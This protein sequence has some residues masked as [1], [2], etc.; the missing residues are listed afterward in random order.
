MNL[1]GPL[2]FRGNLAGRPAVGDRGRPD[3]DIKIIAR[4]KPLGEVHRQAPPKALSPRSR[5]GRSVGLDA[6][7]WIISASKSAVAL[8][9]LETLG[10]G[11][12]SAA[13]L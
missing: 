10:V 8:A 7:G 13:A 6:L 5:A 2:W 1:K 11:S 12:S 3:R 9:A 4:P